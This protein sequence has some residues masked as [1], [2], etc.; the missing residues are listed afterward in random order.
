MSFLTWFRDN[1]DL[2]QLSEPDAPVQPTTIARPTRKGISEDVLARSRMLR[3][4]GRA[5]TAVNPFKIAPVPKGVSVPP[6]MAMD[7]QESEVAVGDWAYAQIQNMIADGQVFLGYPA[8]AEM[9]QRTEYRRISETFAKHMTREWIEMKTKGEEE[10]EDEKDEDGNPFDDNEDDDD[11][12]ARDG[13]V[14]DFKQLPAGAEEDDDAGQKKPG[15]AK[16]D[17]SDKIKQI[18]AELERLNVR[19]AFKTI[20]EQDGFFGRS[21]LYLDTGSTDD[22]DELKL[23]IGT[24]GDDVSKAKFA[25]QG[26][27]KILA[28]RPVEAVWCYPV[29]YNSNDP[30]KASWYNPETWVVMAK[31]VN[32][33]RLL[34]FVGRPVSDLL[35]PAYSFG[36][37]SLSQMC[38]PYVDNWLE[39]RQGVNDIINS[40]SQF[41]LKTNMTESLSDGGDALF[42]RIEFFNN[43]RNNSDTIAVD[44][45]DEDF[46]NVAAPLGSLDKLQAQAQEQQASAAGIPV[47]LLLMIT[48]T[49]LNASSEGELQAF[50][51]WVK[52][53]Q[54]QFFRPHLT[55]IIEL[56]QVLI[57]GDVDPDITFVFK[58]LFGLSELEES[59]VR[60]NDA[61]TDK[62][63][64]EAGILDPIEVRQVLADDPDSRYHGITVEDVPEPPAPELPPGFGGGEE[65]DE[66]R[67]QPFPATAAA[68]A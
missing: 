47:V 4:R 66:A 28:L 61:A 62:A 68:A 57:W 29:G 9:A 18:E 32:K 26:A 19:E 30:L 24:G 14:V 15:N 53:Y 3:R 27:E 23:T 20:A 21:H 22:P 63:Y 35:K 45:T 67:A 41:V 37:L 2:S 17:K 56:I 38:K 60:A 43:V 11:D 8:L 65:D 13:D 12:V 48:P 16:N 36:G 5:T 44:K 34:T 55:T 54:E 31:H 25:K 40:F 7:S 42:K 6:G 49:G 1:F 64:C 46:A 33:T 52:S 51:D 39:T 59:Q 58:P 50:Y 10:P